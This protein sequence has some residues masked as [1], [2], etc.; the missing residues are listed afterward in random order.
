MDLRDPDRYKLGAMLLDLDDPT[1]VL[2]RSRTPILEP[3]F[4]YEN[5]GFK[6][7]VVYSCGAVVN[8]GELYVY[9]GGADAVTCVAMADLD[10]FLKELKA[11]G[12]PRLTAENKTKA[13]NNGRG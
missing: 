12:T 2:Y 5:Q 7:G 13:K 11:H 1:K 10:I 8:D 4:Y 3:D 9:Y 6:S